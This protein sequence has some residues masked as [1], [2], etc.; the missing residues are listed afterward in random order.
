[1]GSMHFLLSSLFIFFIPSVFATETIY[2]E[3]TYSLGMSNVS[4]SE[5]DSGLKGENVEKP[6][7][8]SV[9]S[10]NGQLLWKFKPGLEKS[11]FLSAQV[12]LLSTITGAYFNAGGGAE[13]YFGESGG[14]KMS[15]SNSGTTI[16]M[17]PQRRLFWGLTGDVGYL[18]YV[19][20]TAK[21]TDILVEVGALLGISYQLNEKWNIRSTL[22][23]ARGIGVVTTSM[24][25]NAFFGA[26]MFIG[27]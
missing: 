11:Y 7:S 16:K 6:Y 14:A 10:I 18:S 23:A 26:T 12:P 27:D 2:E 22:G 20:K 4:F 24:N 17:N 13:F 5:T 25:V 3:V 9:S 15:L 19:T 8:G 1:M 21:K